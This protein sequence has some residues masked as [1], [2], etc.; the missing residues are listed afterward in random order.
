MKATKK[1]LYFISLILQCRMVYR[2]FLALYTMI[3][4]LMSSSEYLS[5]S[6]FAIRPILGLLCI[7][8][9]LLC[10][11]RWDMTIV[12]ISMCVIAMS[13]QAKLSSTLGS[14][15]YYWYMDI[16]FPPVIISIAYL[17]VI[18][19]E[20]RLEKKNVHKLKSL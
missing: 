3:D 5:I 15:A 10:W 7:I 11:E 1:A 20:K 2:S 16:C 6:V 9:W 18:V 19:I 13:L 8:T 17:V 14:I 4:I 12:N